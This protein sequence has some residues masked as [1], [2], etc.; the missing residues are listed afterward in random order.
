MKQSTQTAHE[1]HLLDTLAYLIT[2]HDHR[3]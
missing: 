3:Q 2:Y 1:N